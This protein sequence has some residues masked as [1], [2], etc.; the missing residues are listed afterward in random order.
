MPLFKKLELMNYLKLLLKQNNKIILTGFM[1]VGK[2]T[3]GKLLAEQLSCDH[4]DT[5]ELIEQREKLSVKDIFETK[6]ESYFRKLETRI[7]LELSELN[8]KCIVS[9]GGGI[10]IENHCL[11][12]KNFLSF[13]LY[14]SEK[15]I[16]KRINNNNRPLLNINN[17]NQVIKDLFSKRKDLYFQNCDIFINTEDKSIKQVVKKIK[18]EIYNNINR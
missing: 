18:N 5:D 3:V 7:L 1:A 17:K 8:E 14:A 12:K 6:G 9:S 16:H 13:W 10:V 11:I 15:T 4:Y 2:T